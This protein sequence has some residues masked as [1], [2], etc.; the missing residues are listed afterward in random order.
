MT[1]SL[2]PALM[3]LIVGCETPYT[4]CDY[5]NPRLSN[6]LACQRD[7]SCWEP[8]M[9]G[10]LNEMWR[11]AEAHCIKTVDSFSDFR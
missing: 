10:E 5:I 9:Q 6:L 1:K 4:N 8:S 3:L 11:R 7:S 2:L